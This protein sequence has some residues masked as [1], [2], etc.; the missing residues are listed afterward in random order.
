[1]RKSRVNLGPPATVTGT[2]TTGAD[3]TLRFEAGASGSGDF[4]LGIDSLSITR[5]ANFEATFEATGDFHCLST[6][7]SGTSTAAAGFTLNVDSDTVVLDPDYCQ[8]AGA[9]ARG[10]M[11]CRPRKVTE[12]DDTLKFV[13]ANTGGPHIK[14]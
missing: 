9:G 14:R 3:Q 4:L 7:L 10:G 11:G 2:V 1:M 8:V 6:T 5:A 12:S 13:A